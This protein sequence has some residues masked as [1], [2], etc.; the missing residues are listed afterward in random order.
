M[1][2]MR[3]VWWMSN[4][5]CYGTALAKKCAGRSLSCMLRTTLPKAGDSKRKLQIKKCNLGATKFPQAPRP[6]PPS[7]PLRKGTVASGRGSGGPRLLQSC[8]VVASGVWLSSFQIWEAY[9]GRGSGHNYLSRGHSKMVEYR[10]RISYRAL[11]PYRNS[12]PVLQSSMGTSR[13]F[14]VRK[15]CQMLT[16]TKIRNC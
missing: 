10:S 15:H 12:R 4:K 13:R 7:L 14:Q 6:R 9:S 5:K 3:A 11:A 8:A 1:A 16:S 2:V